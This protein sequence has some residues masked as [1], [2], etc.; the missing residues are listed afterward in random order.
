MAPI[1]CNV[2]DTCGLGVQ[3]VHVILE[4]YDLQNNCLASLSSMT[5]DKGEIGSWYPIFPSGG[6]VITQP[7]IVDT[8]TSARATMAFFP[9]PLLIGSAPWTSIRTDVH[10]EYLVN[11][12][13]LHIS[14]SPRL[15][16][17]SYRPTTP[18]GQLVAPRDLHT[19][20]P[21]QLPPP[22]FVACDEDSGGS[23]QKL[24]A[25]GG[26]T[27]AW[28]NWRGAYEYERV[29]KGRRHAE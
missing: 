19:P 16:Y 28:E 12:V 11:Q 1:T 15:E 4:C 21:L 22:E 7:K 2:V 6:N 24:D 23:T 14:E 10:L 27:G 13:T 17:K 9:H 3:G 25:Q 5:D 18:I 20:S 8:T 29:R 26:A